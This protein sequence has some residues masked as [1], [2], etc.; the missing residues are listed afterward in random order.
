MHTNLYQIR[1]AFLIGTCFWLA[2]AVVAIPEPVVI[3]VTAVVAVIAVMLYSLIPSNGANSTLPASLLALVCMVAA[4][5]GALLLIQRLDLLTGWTWPLAIVASWAITAAGVLRFYNRLVTIP[6]GMLH[7]YTGPIRIRSIPGYAKIARPNP[8]FER[9]QAVVPTRRLKLDLE[10]AEI[11]TRQGSRPGRA[12]RRIVDTGPPEYD[13]QTGIWNIYR[14]DLAIEL[15]LSPE[16][17]RAVNRIPCDELINQ[18]RAEYGGRGHNPWHEAR[19]WTGLAKGYVGEIA[20]ELTRELIHDT[21]WSPLD[22]WQRK[23]ELARLILERLR[24]EADNYGIII[25][26]VDIVQVAVDEPEALRRTRDLELMGETWQRQQG[27][28]LETFQTSLQRLGLQLTPAE[29]EHLTRVHLWDLVSHLQHYGHLDFIVDDLVAGL[30]FPH[31][32]GRPGGGPPPS[33]RAIDHL[34]PV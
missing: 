3:A 9:L 30:R 8:L 18:L 4:P 27:L 31:G 16:H 28:V 17:W 33:R 7:V 32:R 5:T 19:Y 21:G 1:R 23:D 10:L 13:H 34:E 2:L 6:P 11:G 29:I 15:A 24:H 25:H 12:P 22:V 20:E 14:L 26:S